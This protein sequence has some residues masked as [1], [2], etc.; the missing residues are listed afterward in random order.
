MSRLHYKIYYFFILL[1]LFMFIFFKN[2]FMSSFDISNVYSKNEKIDNLVD[3]IVVANQQ[4]VYNKNKN[5]CYVSNIDFLENNKISVSSKFGKVKAFL[6][7]SDSQNKLIIYNDKYYQIIDILVTNI[8]IISVYSIDIPQFDHELF[9]DNLF[10]SSTEEKEV[11]NVGVQFFGLSN[12]NVKSTAQMSVRGASSQL[13]NK[14]AFKLKFPNKVKLIDDYRDD[15]WALDALYTD[16]SKIRNKLSSD[17]WNEINNNQNINNDLHVDFCE[18]FIDDEYVG[19]YTLKNKVNK[20]ITGVTSNGILLKSIAILRPYYVENLLSNNFKIED[21]FFLNYEI[22]KYSDSGYHS[23]LTKLKDYYN[24]YYDIVDYDTVAKNYD[25]SNF[26]NYKVFVSLI[27]GDDNV[28]YNQYLSLS[29]FNS[30]ILTTPWDMDLTWGLEWDD[31]DEFH[32]L[33]SVNSS[34]DDI[35]LNEKIIFNMDSKTYDL[36]KQ[37]YWELRED[38]ITM[39]TIN[40]YLDSYEKI[41]VDSGAAARDSERWYQYDVEYEIERIREWANYRIQFLDEYFK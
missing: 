2:I 30:N 1:F 8:P 21:G 12:M 28:T 6:D 22:K 16:K 26:I 40:N 33:F 23:I 7:S 27:S 5:L 4:I 41:L 38:I 34:F 39:D 31:Y 24:Y 15:V 37:R 11:S 10:K 18:L 17:I 3:A 13:F 14:K 19:L 35:W 29:D 36:L 20:D 25:S 32:S 9:Y